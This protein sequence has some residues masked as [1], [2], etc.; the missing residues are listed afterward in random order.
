[1]V[2]CFDDIT[3][4]DLDGMLDRIHDAVYNKISVVANGWKTDSKIPR[5]RTV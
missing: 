1:M 5:E 2:S 3:L 4:D